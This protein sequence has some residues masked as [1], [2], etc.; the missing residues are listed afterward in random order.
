M[1]STLSVRIFLLAAAV[2]LLGLGLLA[3]IMARMHTEDLEKEAVRGALRLSDTLCRSTRYSMLRN[4]KEDVYQ[5]VKTVGDQPGIERIR[6]FNKEGQITFSTK[7]GERG[8]AVDTAAEACTRCHTGANAPLSRLEG[9][10]LTRIFAAPD[11]HRVLG[12]IAPI[13]NEASCAE[14]GCHSPPDKQS[15]LGVLDIQTSLAPIDKIRHDRNR[16]FFFLTYFLMLAI[17]GTCGVFI[18]QFVHQPVKALI[19]GTRHIASGDLTYHLPVRSRTEIGKLA[20]AFNQMAKDLAQAREAL[21][22]WAQTLEQR[23]DEKAETLRQAQTK[24]LQS[25]KLASLGSLSAVVA[26]EINNPLSGIL[27]YTK[28]VR[29]IMEHGLR[30]DQFPEILQYLE[31][32][33]SETA[34]CGKIV[35]N[36]LAFSRQ[37]AVVAGAADLNAIL[38]KTLF[39]IGHKLELQGIAL[40]QNLQPNLPEVVCDSDQIQQAILAVLIN[41]VE[42]MPEGGALCVASA[43][44]TGDKAG[45]RWSELSISDSGPGIPDEV[46]PHLFEP[47]FTTKENKKGVG[48]GLSVVYGIIKR[49]HGRIDVR[50]E[51]GRGSTFVLALPEKAPEE[52]ELLDG[53]QEGVSESGKAQEVPK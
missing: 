12:L 14:A 15:I 7:P 25:E 17:A 16:Q 39:L 41:A 19:R 28:L 46:L 35:G 9:E 26:H 38:E 27:T 34:R 5:I 40:T 18:W 1:L 23:V 3:W 52:R 43:S 48:L 24:L 29:R 30:P 42:A 13:Y 31:A 22:D 6:I 36:L 8:E 44:A 4:Q 10:E 51:L 53:S 20:E 45:E 2:T 32:M 37:S 33:E 21:T 11:G 50:S 47:F 49:H